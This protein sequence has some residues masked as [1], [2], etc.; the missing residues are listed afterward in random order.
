MNLNDS[1]KKE[2]IKRL[3]KDGSTSEFW[4]LMCQAINRDIETL[5]LMPREFASL[6]ADQYKLENEIIREKINYLEG[7]KNKP[8][9]IVDELTDPDQTEVDHDPYR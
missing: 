7:L 1:T 5:R 6:P 8:T 3:M 4:V 9:E 2:E